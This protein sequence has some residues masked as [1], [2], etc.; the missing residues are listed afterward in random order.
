M[1]KSVV[2][3]GALGFVGSH[4]AKFFKTKGY[5]VIGIDW[6]NT[7]PEACCWL[8]Q[9]YTGDFVNV[10]YLAL[11][12]HPSDVIIH[13]A[14]SSLVGPSIQ[15][16]GEYYYNN[17]AKTNRMLD[18]LGTSLKWSGSVI[19]SSSAAV[20]GNPHQIPI[21]EDHS[22]LPV[23]PYG[24]S[25]LF[26]EHVIRSH[27]IAH[28]IRGIALRYFNAAGADP[29][30]DLGHI[31]NDTHLIPEIFSNYFS[32]TLL[33]INGQ[34]FDTPDGT[35][36]RDYVHVTDIASAHFLAADLSRQFDPSEFR[37]YNIGTGKGISNLEI[38]NSCQEYLGDTVPFNFAPAR[39]GDPAVLVA[40]STEFQK[41]SSWQ[42]E[43]SDVKTIV[44]TAG[45]WHK[46]IIKNWNIEQ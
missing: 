11:N 31:L 2:I 44:K 38:V 18:I 24:Y 7:I 37:A 16:P 3:T 26:A 5:R 42:P 12:E 15:N 33:K 6:R 9:S 43:F 25:K 28:G 29:D 21:P 32:K 41:I 46:K 36:I 20:Y 1:S 23:S 8:D 14:G 34:E 40:D 45:D 30:G 10:I 35:C 4:T 17:T 19:F 27:C 22:K 13:C 39:T